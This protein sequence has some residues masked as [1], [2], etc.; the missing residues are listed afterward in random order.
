MSHPTSPPVPRAHDGA[1]NL[2][3]LLGDQE[4]LGV[5]SQLTGYP[6]GLVSWADF[7]PGSDPQLPDLGIIAHSES[8]DLQ[9]AGMASLTAVINKNR[10]ASI[11][12]LRRWL[13]NPMSEQNAL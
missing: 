5:P 10:R 3:V 11:G 12:A 4:E 9:L 2:A 13:A 1:D 6:L 8:P 7:Q